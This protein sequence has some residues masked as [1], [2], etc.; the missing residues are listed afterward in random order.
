[1]NSQVY[2]ESEVELKCLSLVEKGSPNGA[3]NLP[4]INQGKDPGYKSEREREA[5]REK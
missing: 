2:D 5:E 3:P 4:F 1:M